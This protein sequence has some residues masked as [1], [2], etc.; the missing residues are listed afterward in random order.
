MIHLGSLIKIAC[1]KMVT[2]TFVTV[3]WPLFVNLLAITQP[4]Y[5]ILNL[6]DFN[7]FSNPKITLEYSFYTRV[8]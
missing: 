5:S 7:T 2:V 8:W 1:N 6:V 3:Y 4:K